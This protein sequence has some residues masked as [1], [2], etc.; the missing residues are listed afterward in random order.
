VFVVGHLGDWRRAAAVLFERHSLSGHPAPRREKGQDASERLGFST[1]GSLSGGY[2]SKLGTDESCQG[3]VIPDWPAQVCPTLDTYYGDKMG[4]EDQHVYNQ[5]GGKFVPAVYSLQGGGRTSQNSQGSGFKEDVSFTLNCMD[6]HAV[7]VSH[8]N[9]GVMPAVAY[10]TSG[11]CGAWE[12]G[13]ITGALDTNTDPNS[14]V[15]RQASAVR[16]LTPVECER[17]QGF[18]TTTRSFPI[19]ESP[20]PMARATRRSE[21]AWRFPSCAGSVSALR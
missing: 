18:P 8:A 20:P 9:G 4:L 21:T 11:N 7:A 6:E 14:H 10:Q 3:S 12:T 13:D 16:R 1:V 5:R 17:L 2:G 19:A 15:L